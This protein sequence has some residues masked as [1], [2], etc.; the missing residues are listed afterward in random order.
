MWPSVHPDLPDEVL[1]NFVKGR[2]GFLELGTL[3][4]RQSLLDNVR[5]SVL[6]N[7]ARD[8]EEN[9]LFDSVNTLIA[10]FKER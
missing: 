8:G 5:N 6:T 4:I 3:G 7:D 2:G 1:S 10:R 9:G